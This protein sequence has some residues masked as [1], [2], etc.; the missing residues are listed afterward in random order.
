ML[1]NL[2]GLTGSRIALLFKCLCISSQKPL[3]TYFNLKLISAQSFQTFPGRTH[4]QI[5]LDTHTFRV[6][7]LCLP[8]S[9]QRTLERTPTT[10]QPCDIKTNL[11]ARFC[12]GTCKL[13]QNGTYKINPFNNTVIQYTN[14]QILR[15]YSIC[16]FQWFCLAVKSIY[17]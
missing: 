8:N 3:R 6:H 5:S 11:W 7:K 13:Y 14:I 12:C 15:T 2:P 10:L 4:R 16:N 1:L 17:I 9:G